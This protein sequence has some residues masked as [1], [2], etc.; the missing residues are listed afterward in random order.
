MF[1]GLLILFVLLSFLSPSDCETIT[2]GDTVT[3]T[4]SAET[5][6]AK[7][8]FMLTVISSVMLPVVTL[9]LGFY[10]GTEKSKE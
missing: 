3:V 10:F 8:D 1:V 9:V 6:K 4:C 7:A 2:E 5:W